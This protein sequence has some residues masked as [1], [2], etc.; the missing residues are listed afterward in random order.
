MEQA[1][2]FEIVVNRKSARDLGI[3]LPQSVLLRADAV[4]P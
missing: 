2:K 3:A 1:S 4:V